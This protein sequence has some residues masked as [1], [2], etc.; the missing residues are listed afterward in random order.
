MA[1]EKNVPVLGWSHYSFM[2]KN[3]EHVRIFGPDNIE[4]VG[5]SLSDYYSALKHPTC[6]N[7]VG[8][9]NENWFNG[10]M[11]VTIELISLENAFI[12]TK[13]IERKASLL[14]KMQVA[15]NKI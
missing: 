8:M 14:S 15:A 1:K 9:P 5:F 13:D 6:M 7:I 12:K 11:K 10:R 2:G 4:V 3:Q